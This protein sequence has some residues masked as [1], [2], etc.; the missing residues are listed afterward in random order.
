MT[1]QVECFVVSPS[2]T[3]RIRLRRF[4]ADE[5]ECPSKENYGYHQAIA[6]GG[7]FE[8]ELGQEL[9][10]IT[11]RETLVPH[12]DVR[13]PTRCACGLAFK[14]DDYK[15]TRFDTV[16]EDQKGGS[17]LRSDLPP[18][19]MYRATHL[20]DDKAFCGLDGQSWVVVLPD[21]VHWNI[22]SRCNNCSLPNDDVHKCW[23]RHGQAPK[24]TVNKVGNT[25]SAGGGSIQTKAYHGFLTNGYLVQ[26]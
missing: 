8:L 25:C 14:D 22:D 23:C 26:C 18:G 10:P 2:K 20:E 12:S 7:S 24:F 13:W 3:L 15:Q 4:S 11:T 19:A 6:E 1:N 17:W 21:G 9:P 16:Y 5:G